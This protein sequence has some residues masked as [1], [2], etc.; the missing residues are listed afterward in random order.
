MAPHRL[1]DRAVIHAGPAADAAEHLLELSAKHVSPAVV[2]QNHVILLGPVGVANALRAGR[3]RCVAREFLT[4]GRARQYPEDG[5]RV[6]KRGND[7]LEAR[8]NDMNLRDELGEVP[9]AFIEESAE[10]ELTEKS[11]ISFCKE[12]L[13]GFKRPKGV[14][15]G[16][17][18][19]T[20]TGKIQKFLLRQKV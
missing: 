12:N 15:F 13:A 19:K 16:P 4:R 9:I 3:Q 17:I 10:S 14:F 5:R 18:P 2:E 11:V 20:A 8:Q 1:I 7:L 6:L